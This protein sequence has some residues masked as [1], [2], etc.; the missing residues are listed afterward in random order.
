[1]SKAWDDM[2]DVN[3]A[4]ALELMGGK[5]QANVLSAIIKNFDTVEDVIQTSLDYEGSAYKENE[6][7]LS[8]IQGRIDLLKN[9]TQTMWT[10]A[11]NNDAIKFF[12]DLGTAIIKLVDD[13]GLFKTALGGLFAASSLKG[14]G[15]EFFKKTSD[16]GIGFGDL[17]TKTSKSAP[18]VDIGDMLNEDQFKQQISDLVAAFDPLN[19]TWN[20][21]VS[22]LQ[23]ADPAMKQVLAGFK[24]QTEAA[25]D[26]AGAYGTYTRVCKTAG[27]QIQGVG[28]KSL[29]ASIGVRA[30][31][32]ALSMGIGL[33]VGL[34]IEGIISGIDYLIHR[35]EKLKEEV[36]DL[37]REYKNAKEEFTKNIKELTESS[38][39]SLYKDLRDEF[40]QLAK[41]VDKYGNNIDLTADA[42]NRYK[43][44]CEKI[45]GIQPSIASGYDSATEAIGNNVSILERLIE[46]QKIQARNDAREY[47]SD[48]NLKKQAKASISNYK[49][50]KKKYS[51]LLEAPVF[52][53]SRVPDLTARLYN[54]ISR[55]TTNYSIAD[56]LLNIKYQDLD[57]ILGISGLKLTNG[58]SSIEYLKKMTTEDLGKIVDTLNSLYESG[59]GLEWTDPTN[60][61]YSMGVEQIGIFLD[62]FSSIYDE[63]MNKIDAAE[64]ELKQKKRALVETLLQV[65][66]SM[67]EYEKLSGSNQN[68]ITQWIKNSK[69]FEIDKNTDPADVLGMKTSIQTFIRNLSGGIYKYVVKEADNI[70]GVNAGDTIDA[71]MILDQLVD[72]NPSNVDYATY[73]KQV[74]QLVNML[75]ESLG[76]EGQ[77]L[78][79]NDKN[80]LA[81]S[82]GFDF[83]T[84]NNDIAKQADAIAERIKMDSKV[85]Q[86]KLQQ[87]TPAEVDAFLKIDWNTT[88]ISS[89][90][91]VVAE[92]QEQAQSFDAFSVDMFSTISDDISKFNEVLSQT[93]EIVA[94]NTEVSKEYKESL[95][96][97]GFSQEELNDVFD[98]ANPLLVKNAALLRKLVA[99]KK[100]EKRATVQ[101]A[102]ANNL[103]QY[104]NTVKQLQQIV[105]A[106]ATERNSATGVTK[107]TLKTVDALRSQLTTLK[108]TQREYA[109]L[110]IQL[111]GATN[112]YENFEKAKSMDEKLTY[113]DSMIEM[114]NTLNDGFKTGQVGTEAF[115]AAVATLVPSSVYEDLDNFN[116]RMV[117]IHDYVDKNPLF[118]DWFT[119]K[120]GE[121]SI[122][123]ENIQNFV[124]DAQKA[125]AFTGSDENGNFE[126]GKDVETID[127]FVSKINKAQDGVGVTKEA[128][129]AMITEFSKY[130]ATWSDVLYDLTTNKFDKEVNKTTTELEK[131]VAAQDEY[132]RSGKS[133]D[134]EE[135]KTICANVENA[136]AAL[137][138]ANAAA[139]Q[140]TD[141]YTKLQ[142]LYNMA[143]GK[144]KGTK[145]EADAL[146]KSL[147]LVDKNGKDIT[148]ELDENGKLKL[149]TEQAEILNQKLGLLK[150]PTVVSVQFDFDTL[151]KQLEVAKKYIK[152]DE[153]SEEDKTVLFN[154]GI[155]VD[156]ITPEQLQA[157]I[158][159]LPDDQKQV[160]LDA[161]IN[162]DGLS[163]EEIQQKIDEMPDEQKQVLLN[164]G[165]KVDALTADELTTACNN[166]ITTVEP[167]LKSISLTYGITKTSEEQQ[168]GTIEKL[169][170]WEV[171]GIHFT[172]YAE[173]DGNG[174]KEVEDL[175]A[176]KD[177]LSEPETTTYTVNGTGANTVST[178]SSQWDNITGDKSTTY[179]V[180]TN[181]VGSGSYSSQKGPIAEPQVNGTAHASGSWGAD[182]SSTSLV[183]ELGPELRVRGNHWAMLGENGAEFTDVKKGDIIFN[184]K[185][186]KSLLENGYINSRG[187]AYASGTNVISNIFDNLKL[188]KLAKY[189]E[190]MCKQYEELVNGNV[191]LRKRPHLSPSYEHDLAMGGGYNSFIGSDGEIYAS[192]S[193]ETVTIGD[194][195]KYTIDI[196]PV[197]EN[198]DV[199]TS[200]ALADYI[201]GLVTNGSTQDLLDSDKYNLVIRAVPGEYDEKDWAGFEGELSKYK[202]GYLNTIME[203]FNIG[204]EK[205]V[206][207]SGFSSV[208][209][210]GVTKDLQDNGSYTGKEVASAIDD[211][212]D[213]MRELDNLINQYVTD[214]LNAKSLADDIGTDL[215][216]TKYGNVDT[217]DRQKLY[218]DEESLDKYGDAIDSWGMKA[219]DLAGTYSTLLS[220]V[221]EFDGEDIAFTPILQTENGP[222]LLDSNTVDKYI[223]G[224]I[225][226]AKQNDGKWTSDELFQLDTKG[227]EVDGVVVKNLL[228]GI[229]QDADKTAKLL[230]YVGDTGAISS[231]EGEIESTSSE[232]V[233][234]GENITAVQAKLD[235]LNAT[236]ISDKTFTVTTDYRTIG[237]GTE[238]TI[239]TPGASGRLTIY[240]DG[241]AHAS[242]DWGLKQSEHNSLVGELG[243]ETVVDPHTGKYY[244]VGDKGAELVDLPKDAI[245]F[246]HKQT[247]ELFKNGHIG[248]RGKM[249]KGQ[250]FAEGNAHYGL[251]TGYTDY[252][253]VFKNGS[254]DWVDAWDDTLRSISD[255]AD[256][257][258][259]AGDDLSDAADDFEEMFDWF[260]VLLEEI[261]DDLN[262]V[263]AKLE[264]AVGISAKNSLQDE[265]ININKLKLTEL[266]EGYKL[267]ADYAAELLGKV[268]EQYRDLAEKGGVALTHFLGEANQEVVEAINNYREWAQKASDVRT[269]QQQ[270]KKE[271]TSISLEKVQTIADEYDRVITKITTLND[272]LQANVDLIEEQGE[273]TSAVMYEEMIKNSSKEL[274]ELQKKRDAMQKE[275]DAQVSA[276]NIDVG[277]EEWYEGISAIQDVDKSIIDC[278]KDIEGFQ[279]SINQ[280]HWDNFDGLIE[281]IDNVGN[282]ISNLGDLIDDEDIADEMG[283]WTDKGITKMGLLAQEM[284]RAQYRAKQ[285]AEQ[286]G[287]LN[288]EYAAGKYS[289][290]E[291]NEKLQEL[292]DGQWDSIKS[293][294]AAKDA[295][296]DLNKTRVDAA[297]NAMQKEI[298]AYNELINKKKEELQLSK[299]AHDFSKQVA[300]QQ[301]NIASIQKQ[302][303]AI[304]GDNSASAIARRKKLEAEL[305]SA[306]EELDEL[307]YN[308]SIEK[309]QDALDDQAESYQD[310]KEKEM[311]ALDEYLKNV[312]Q[313]IAD[314]F[315]T[316]TGNTEAVAE[317]LK[318]I[319]DEYGI[320]LSEAITNPW[321]QG[322]IAIGTY[323]DQLDTSMSAFTAQ[324]DAIKKQLLDLQAEA[325]N[326]ARHL[327]DAT[328]QK[329]NK[330]S[331]ATYT[332]PAPS[333]PSQPST[334]QKPAAPSNGSSVTV[335]KSATN[336]TRDG[337]NGTRMQS[338]VPGSTFTVYQVSGSEVLIGRNGQ[339]TGW[340]RLSDL[341]GYA[342]GIK[343]V[344]NNQLA[345]TDELGLE[346]LVLHAGDNGRLQYLSKGSSVI[347]AD[348]TD[349]LMKLGSLDPKDIL[350][351]NRPKIGAPYIVNNSIE[352]NMSFGNMINIEHADKDSIPEIKDV[353]K[354]QLDS[355]MKNINSSLKKYTR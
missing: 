94:N 98:E 95:T 212:S 281:A 177:K 325:D 84:K 320:N 335:K 162:F 11:I 6:K 328:N 271:I 174:K 99:Q 310:E 315:A 111:S 170:N 160:L 44:I 136:E 293:Y 107:A 282:E 176:E 255:S 14:K 62:E 114:L 200:D 327:I 47:V 50:A 192:T 25:M 267:Y 253:E 16:G 354:A 210:A 338:W 345:I 57:A 189:A 56:R 268:P 297:K 250:A 147:G 336:F 289:T 52:D 225:D 333:T 274:D 138:K 145:D 312:E 46:L 309:Q 228:E 173:V 193:A 148:F 108:Q 140:N 101:M 195:N 71:S 185:Q 73:Q 186:T 346:E 7:Y 168:D 322:V 153:L 179:T 306:Q 321:E 219:D 233:A 224:L 234:T 349:N 109:L 314:S 260:A 352:L 236:S 154:A 59:E 256:S 247:E 134:G 137:N 257:L 40:S 203:M 275:F 284:E 283:N 180:K 222:Q 106:M 3:R 130:D 223:W 197:L 353:V 304:A 209:L 184:H 313:V 230:H 82:I 142:T 329:A 118:A 183:G 5:R 178:I 307:Y 175:N 37:T 340:V 252:E 204:G 144:I 181:Y 207:S 45:V 302:L 182:H 76:V 17:F 115:Q 296:V 240:A 63:S 243:T 330:T 1:M 150:E 127:D 332:P 18:L 93:E 41:G 4:A 68:F 246:N 277:S 132:I 156:K 146:A 301:K 347:P 29:A 285:Y 331:S 172:A 117:A 213:G 86:Y 49:D 122:T 287:Y 66:A 119:I 226:E 339:Y 273:R 299:D 169:K 151:S 235:K 129:V 279:N 43:A 96:A 133:L 21:Y 280:L 131:A 161:G 323:Q 152:G 80:V 206:E 205:A 135:W 199:L 350:D 31:N 295:L 139:Q 77:K 319:A 23:G 19:N 79:N 164:A 237:S 36:A 51:E 249:V 22:K 264:N 196:T 198:G 60:I 266:G 217:N 305:A 214:V 348:I 123:Q 311:E 97:L 216:Q 278:R 227:L 337:G 38:D 124:D 201:D 251:F 344:P 286:I 163:K 342:K 242:G 110:E 221:G 294:E 128:V 15:L 74:G 259:G 269:Q 248:S 270:V 141:Q 9:T 33:I 166:L 263:S 55:D 326:T 69:M 159:A 81:A 208:G 58:T 12:V 88:D 317:T 261:D 334:P 10:D 78:F 64:E 85:I 65:P 303:A 254:N 83:T 91:D 155:N 218:W 54:A 300:E 188:K 26:G 231:L 190:E 35:T 229:G 191:D 100:E 241:T 72:I 8:S 220:S 103:L 165:I 92:I 318:G 341:E 32:A 121:F 258:S 39:A 120:D 211:T 265:M 90:N 105:K 202:D 232:L 308:H 351:R 126:L 28:V 143:Q 42:Y 288:Q 53:E 2:T 27:V 149:T 89:W 34:A 112:A 125:G 239:H 272:L 70:K 113:G 75:W 244:T 187:K 343:K 276:G 245:I 102:K 13:I 20:D 355:Y 292:K 291:Y 87:M 238:R 158:N 104:R 316:I 48:E 167:T 171:N 194:K 298:D 61:V 116:D 215:S 30:L 67:S 24:N 290:D 324:L 157:K 262:Y